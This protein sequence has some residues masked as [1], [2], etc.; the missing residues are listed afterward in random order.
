M[1]FREFHYRWEWEI[2]ATPEEFWPYAADTNRFNLDAGLAPLISNKRLEKGV[3]RFLA[4]KQ[5]GLVTIAFE[6][7][8]FQWIYPH[9][10]GVLR[11]YVQGPL[12]QMS[13]RVQLQPRAEGGTHLIYE[14]WVTPRNVLGWLAIPIQVNIISRRSFE[15]TFRLYEQLIREQKPITELPAKVRLEPQ[16]QKRLTAARAQLLAQN[17]EERLVDHLLAFLQEAD[18]FSTAA[19]RPYALAKTWQAPRKQVLELFLLATRVGVVDFQWE[20]L[21]PM[22]RGSGNNVAGHLAD[23]HSTVHCESCNID[24]TANFE[25]SVE[26]TFRPSPAIRHVEKLQ[27]CVAGPMVTPHIVAQQ[28]VEAG[29]S[30][31]L[32]LGLEVGRYRLRTAGWPGS[33]ALIVAEAGGR[34]SLAITPTAEAW[35]EDEKMLAPQSE[36]VLGN[37]TAEPQ[38]FVLE[39][40]AWSDEAVTA[41]EVTTMQKFRDLF[42]SEAIRTGE[43]FAVGSVAILFTDLIDSTRMYNEIG[44]APAFGLVINHFE[45]LRQ[46]VDQEE[47]AVVKTIGDA[48]MAVFRRPVSALRAITRAQEILSHTPEGQPPIRLKAGIHYGPCI[49]V[50]LNERL[51]YF[52]SAVNQAAR[53]EGFAGGDNVVITEQVRYDPEVAAFLANSPHFRTEPFTAHLKGFDQSDFDLWRVRRDRDRDER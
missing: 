8:P 43:Q 6:E 44:D 5:F 18:D 31:V 17:Q 3:G 36:L 39:R 47:G 22:C 26:I 37:G 38:M 33:Q 9:Q 4:F 28:M 14:V 11:R 32:P 24:F 41:A 25:R 29:E 1:A 16:A 50:T 2:A 10:F 7:E 42:A 45:V 48:I 53:L 34:P 12:S 46:M 15:R 27:Y 40:M 23:L 13:V 19:I 35:D 51:D 21:C 30:V 49:A 20:L 52:G